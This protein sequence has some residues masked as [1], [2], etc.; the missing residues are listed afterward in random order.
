MHWTFRQLGSPMRYLWIS[1][2]SGLTTSK[3]TYDF[4]IPTL[5]GLAAVGVDRAFGI[6]MGLS[7]PDGLLSDVISLLNLLI[8]FFI[9]ALAAVATFDR[10]GL[11]EKMKGEPAILR[12]KN[13]KGRK[14]EIIL[15]HRQFV[16]YLFGY[17]SFSSLVFLMALYGVKIFSPQISH[18]AV[19]LPSVTMC[20]KYFGVFFFF[21][22]LG[23]IA[24]TM[25]L[26]IHFLTDRL[27]F[28]DNPDI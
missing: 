8:A 16:C 25:L 23:Q 19:S 10:K 22:M 1:H 27:Q 26:G 3:K 11:D 15:T 28:M 12:R 6:N 17:L 2:G 14:V 18:I 20:F 7:A 21:A 4:A 5:I 24:T 13:N 9:A